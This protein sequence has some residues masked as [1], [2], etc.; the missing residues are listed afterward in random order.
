MTLSIN[1]P[2]SLQMW[3]NARALESARPTFID[4]MPR[5]ALTPEQE[6]VRDA[7]YAEYLTAV[8]EDTAKVPAFL[9]ALTAL[10]QEHGVSVQ[11]SSE[12]Y[13]PTF[14]MTLGH[15]HIEEINIGGEAT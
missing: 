13:Y 2:V 14:H 6:A 8:A 4:M 3:G 10:C 15:A 12:Q 1:S 5:P 9:A 7:I 11:G